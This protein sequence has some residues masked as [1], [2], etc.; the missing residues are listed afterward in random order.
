M[1]VRD[2]WQTPEDLFN[3]LNFLFRFNLDVCATGENSKCRKFYSP[4]D[5][6]LVQRWGGYRCWM[7]PPFSQVKKW[8]RRASEMVSLEDE[9]PA[10]CV[11]GLVNCDTS[12]RWWAEYMLQAGEIWYLCPGRVQF[13]PPPGIDS[14]MNKF[15]SALGLF[16]PQR[17]PGARRV[18]RY[19]DWQG[20]I[21]GDGIPR[22]L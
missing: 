19:F 15:P 14:S 11:I 4:E 1:S 8:V 12:T 5:D 20:K 10:E 2:N 16:F 3:L 22:F 6:G 13:I 17:F 9:V 21:A 18:D 7:N